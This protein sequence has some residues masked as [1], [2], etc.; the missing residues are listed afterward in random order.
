MNPW[1]DT[2]LGV[3]RAPRVGAAASR[4]PAP[5]W[6]WSRDGSR[7][8]WANPAGGRS[9]GAASF[10][11][12][13]GAALAGGASA[14]P[15]DRE[16]RARASR[17][18][19]AGAAAACRR[20]ARAADRLPLP[21]RASP[22]TSAAFWS[23]RS[24]RRGDAPSLAALASFFS[25]PDADVA[26][27]DAAGEACSPKRRPERPPRSRRRRR[28]SNSPTRAERCG[29]TSSSA[30]RDRGTGARRPADARARRRRAGHAPSRARR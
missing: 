17:A 23:S 14:A 9:L 24:R 6:I 13:C 3:Q 18:G 15:R 12:L 19:D 2:A 20:P 4:P 8:L 26:I 1:R 11:A 22:A 21:P 10:A 30:R 5:A 25:G 27:L 7:V 16:P 29:S 28:T